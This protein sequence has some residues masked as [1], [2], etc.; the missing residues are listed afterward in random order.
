MLNEQIIAKIEAIPIP[1]M[2]VAIWLGKPREE[3]LILFVD[4]AIMEKFIAPYCANYNYEG[5]N[6]YSFSFDERYDW[7][8]FVEY[9]DA[10]NMC[11]KQEVEQKFVP[12]KKGNVGIDEIFGCSRCMVVDCPEEYKSTL[13]QYGKFSLTNKMIP[14]RYMFYVDSRF[15]FDEVKQYLLSL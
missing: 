6:K 12:V 10:I 14:D 1:Q 11:F 2:K 5:K 3:K 4:K 15:D 9:V 13:E 8:E 7:N